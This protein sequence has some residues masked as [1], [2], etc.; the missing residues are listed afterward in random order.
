VLPEDVRGRG[1]ARQVLAGRG[2]GSGGDKEACEEIGGLRDERVRN[3]LNPHV[4]RAVHHV[5]SLAVCPWTGCPTNLRAHVAG[6]LVTTQRTVV[7][8]R[9]AVTVFTG[10]GR[11]SL[12]AEEV[13]ASRTCITGTT[14]DGGAPAD[15]VRRLHPGLLAVPTLVP[16]RH[17]GTSA[18][19]AAR[20]GARVTDLT[21]GLATA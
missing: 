21:T 13:V 5:A 14:G 1:S 17:L 10:T 4:T 19:G 8:P 9:E 6:W 11:P 3:L 16:R 15:V 18:R 20:G 2:A 12:M 7:S